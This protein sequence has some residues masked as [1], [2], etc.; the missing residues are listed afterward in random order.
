[1]TAS[2]T[3]VIE[4]QDATAEG[5]WPAACEQG[6]SAWVTAVLEAVEAGDRPE[7]PPELVI[8][9]VDPDEGRQLNAQWRGKDYA[10]NVLSFPFEAPPGVP[11][12]PILGDLVL[13]ADVVEAEAREQ[14]KPLLDHWA[15]LLIHGTLH[16]LGYDH[17]NDEDADRMEALERRILARF[18]IP[19]PYAP[20]SAG[21]APED[22]S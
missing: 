7:Q 12:P 5:Q 2:A 17:L 18:A 8:R 6:V 1:M 14:G 11:A 15:H 21:K 9:I 13:T 22:A 16:L 4:V 19:D 10:T 20:S 3:P